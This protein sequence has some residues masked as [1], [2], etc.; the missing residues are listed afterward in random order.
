MV[1][2]VVQLWEVGLMKW[3]WIGLVLVS[4]LMFGCSNGLSKK[5]LDVGVDVL[6]LLVDIIDL[7]VGLFAC[8][9]CWFFIE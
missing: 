3:W 7:L 6:F 1:G 8:N 5:I 2:F 4:V 9:L